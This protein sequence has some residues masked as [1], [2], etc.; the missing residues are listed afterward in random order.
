MPPEQAAGRPDQVTASADVYSV[1]AILY[2]MCCGRPPFQ[3]ATALDTLLQVLESEATLPSSVRP[4]VS[5][6]LELI[7]MRC[8]EKRPE[9]RYSSAESLAQDLRRYQ[10]RL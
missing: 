10:H 1:G 9:D 8:L 3:A 6:V 4:G 7:C 2:A 5:Q